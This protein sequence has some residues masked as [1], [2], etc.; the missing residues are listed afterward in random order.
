MAGGA[1]RKA[2][3]HLYRSVRPD[4][5][6][7]GSTGSRLV[8]AAILGE[9]GVLYDLD[10]FAYLGAPD[11]ATQHVFTTRKELGLTN[12][13]KLRTGPGIRIGA[14]SVGHNV[15]IAGRLFALFIGLKEPKFVV[16]YSGPEVDVALERGEIDARSHVVASLMQRTPEWV[17]KKLMDFH[18]VLETPK[19]NR[20]PRFAHLPEIESFTQSEKERKIL[21]LQRAFRLAGS[22]WVLPPGMPAD[23]VEILQEAM[24][25]T[26]KDPAFLEA[27]KK[28]AGEEAAPVMPEELSRVIKELPRDPEVVALFNR[29]AGPEALPERVK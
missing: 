21:G 17:E 12:L 15:Y 29:I 5:L 23:R 8:A 16:G 14:Q 2:A 26:F 10:K 28:A 13:D 9:S 22:A 11:G 27:Y 1:G 7:I 24:R 6:T 3:N 4:G 25:K 20:H 18:A 19:G